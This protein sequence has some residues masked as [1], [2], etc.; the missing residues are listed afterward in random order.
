MEG[1][2]RHTIGKLRVLS[3]RIKYQKPLF[4]V[5]LTLV[6]VV[7]EMSFGMSLFGFV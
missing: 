7:V 1:Y 2:H 4:F 5:E 6:K 3:A